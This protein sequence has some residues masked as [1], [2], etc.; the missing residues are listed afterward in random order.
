VSIFKDA[1]P[2][3]IQFRWRPIV[4]IDDIG[5]MVYYRW[6]FA[7]QNNLAVPLYDMMVQDTSFTYSVDKSL[8]QGVY[9]WWVVGFTGSGAFIKSSNVGLVSVG[10]EGVEEPAEAETRPPNSP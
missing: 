4:D 7:D 10:M 6:F 5:S 2:D 9:Y 3:T 8:P 1:W